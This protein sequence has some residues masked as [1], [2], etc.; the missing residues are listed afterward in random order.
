LIKEDL[1]LNE[2][3]G[4]INQTTEDPGA[5]QPKTL[6]ILAIHLSF[7]RRLNHLQYYSLYNRCLLKTSSFLTPPDERGWSLA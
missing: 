7:S 2:K 5:T 1:S 3:T 6:P 4:E